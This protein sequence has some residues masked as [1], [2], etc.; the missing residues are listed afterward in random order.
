MPDLVRCPAFPRI[1]E[2][3]GCWSIEPTAAA[4]MWKMAAQTDLAAHFAAV[5]AGR[6][7]DDRPK[8]Q[9]ERVPIKNGQSIARIQILG[10]M[11]KQR[12][13]FGGTSTIQLRRDVRAAAND[14]EIAAIL[15]EIESPGGTSAG[16]A[17]LADD[18]RAARKRKLVWAHIEDLG[19]SAAYWVASQAGQVFANRAA[20]VGSVGTLWPLYDF[21]AN[22]EADGI[23][24]FTFAT[25]SLKATGLPGTPVTEEQQKYRQGLVN[26]TQAEFERAVRSGRGLG[27]QELAKVRTG[28]VFTAA[29]AQRLKLIDGVRPLDRTI[30]ALAD[31]AGQRTR[32][33][34]AIAGG[35]EGAN[36]AV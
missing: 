27:D 8:S 2:Y 3:L 31:A 6:K 13:S 24:V 18:V 23:R 28:A 22:Y 35:L 9:I 7:R 32:G 4:A 14:P 5:K 25:G 15:L 34:R 16:T 29:E 36:H 26:D 30:E 17:E 1:E 20:M 12:S 19:A 11:M 21:S 33:S 10:T